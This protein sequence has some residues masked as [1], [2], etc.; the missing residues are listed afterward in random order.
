MREAPA[1]HQEDGVLVV[2]ELLLGEVEV[3]VDYE[4]SEGMLSYDESHDD[5]GVFDN[6]PFA[7]AGLPTSR[8]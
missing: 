4:L 6:E 3:L 5:E 1:V 2:H 8:A 7:V